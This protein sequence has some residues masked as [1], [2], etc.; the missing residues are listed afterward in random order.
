MGGPPSPSRGYRDDPDALS[1]HT[2]RGDIFTDDA[3]EDVPDI[4]DVPP[5]AYDDATVDGDTAWPT[6]SPEPR[7]TNLQVDDVFYT[8][9]SAPQTH[10][11][12][13]SKRIGEKR[14]RIANEVISLQDQR[15]DADP[16]FLESWVKLMARLPPSPYIHIVGTHK[17]AKRDKDGKSRREEVTDFR[18]LVSLRNY[19]WP[20][21][22]HNG[23][24]DMNLTTSE[25]G[26]KTYRGTVLKKRAPGVKGDIEVGHAKP[27]L[28]EWCHRYCAKA[29]ATKVFRLSR[30][31]TGLDE[32][33]I[34]FRLE[35]LIRSTNYKG[36]IDIEFP[37][38]DR[39]VDIYSSSRLNT[40]R[41]TGWICWLFYLTFLWI[42]SWPI[43]FFTTKRYHVV[44]AEWPFSQTN[45]DGSKRYT[46]VSETQWISRYGTAVRQLCLDRYEGLA[47]DTYLNEVLD[48]LE[49]RRSN[50]AQING[51]AAMSAAAAAFQGGRFDAASSRAKVFEAFTD[52]LNSSKY[53]RL[54]SLVTGLLYSSVSKAWTLTSSAVYT[55]PVPKPA[56]FDGLSVIPHKTLVNNITSLAAFADETDTPPLN[57]LFATATL[58]PSDSNMQDMFRSLNK[59]IYSFDPEGGVTWSIAFE[60]LVAAMLRRWKDTN[61]L[62]LE[63]AQDGFIVLIS[64]LWP[65][66]NPDVETKARSVLTEWEAN[67]REKRLLQRFQYLNYAAPFQSPLQSYGKDKLEFLKLVSEKY[68]PEQMLQKRVGGFKLSF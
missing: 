41:L 59:T 43:L 67:A 53:D 68:D 48:R 25:A 34:Q 37:V 17:E 44:R 23:P 58:K 64:A 50:E 6:G 20:N 51:R 39:A 8:G 36:H 54:A 62:G 22:A 7:N 28:K 32:E 12:S 40:W 46:T 2:T 3:A 11:T 14:T 19:L 56:I 10:V 9:V 4:A 33:F 35:G 18:I 38:A 15:S 1:M 66:T 31:V 55:E 26:E 29:T 13:T 5:P 60:P 49:S 65:K 57:W 61:V 63:S 24:N 42:F 45:A 47:G 21:F 52:L 16:G 27:H 30:T